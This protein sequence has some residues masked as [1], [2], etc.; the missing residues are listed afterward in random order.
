MSDTQLGAVVIDVAR[1]PAS[2]AWLHRHRL[3]KTLYF[4]CNLVALVLLRVSL[5][6]PPNLAIVA[7]AVL[8]IAFPHALHGALAKGTP[9]ELIRT[10]CQGMSRLTAH[11][12]ADTRVALKSKE[13]HNKE[14]QTRAYKLKGKLGLDYRAQTK[15]TTDK[16]SLSAFKC[17]Q[18]RRTARASASDRRCALRTWT[19]NSHLPAPKH[20]LIPSRHHQGMFCEVDIAHVHPSLFPDRLFGGS[21]LPASIESK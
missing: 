4:D 21:W 9:D 18:R 6:Q 5:T 14:P 15:P 12:R 10:L 16:A 3:M 2:F 19:V 17:A 7:V 20:Q 11:S 8:H 13:A 1:L